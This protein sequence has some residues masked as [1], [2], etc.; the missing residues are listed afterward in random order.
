M[1]IHTYGDLSMAQLLYTHHMV[2]SPTFWQPTCK[3]QWRTIGFLS[4]LIDNWKTKFSQ[5]IEEYEEKRTSFLFPHMTTRML[6]NSHYFLMA[7]IPL[8]RERTGQDLGKTQT[9]LHI[10]LA[11]A[12][13]MYNMANGKCL[14]SGGFVSCHSDNG[15]CVLFVNQFVWLYWLSLP[16]PCQNGFT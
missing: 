3:S 7:L 10:V 8:T 15:H 5:E 4:F 9:F 13:V 11:H 12:V 2:H 16:L 14:L 6:I 1:H